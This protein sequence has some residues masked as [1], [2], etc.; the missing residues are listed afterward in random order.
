MSEENRKQVA[1][2]CRA[3]AHMARAL[4]EVFD[5]KGRVFEEGGAASIIDFVG[6]QT[7]NLMETLGDILN[8][9]DATDEDEDAWLNPVFEAAQRIYLIKAGG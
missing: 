6:K 1:D 8:G 9:M 3:V 7:A 2:Q 5:D 4:A